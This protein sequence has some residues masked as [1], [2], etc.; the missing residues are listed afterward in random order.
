MVTNMKRD[1]EYGSKRNKDVHCLYPL[2]LFPFLRKP[3][4][5]IVDSDN[6]HVFQH[7][8]RHFGQPFLVLMSPEEVPPPLHEEQDKGSLFTLFLH[9]P[10]TAICLISTIIEIPYTLWEEAQSYIDRFYI[11]AG[12]QLVRSKNVDPVYLQFY[13][14]DFLRLLVLRFIFCSCITK[15]HRRFRVSSNI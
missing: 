3:F 2:D 6:S 15:M 9:S 7:I 5:L 10:L 12:K 14:D 11:E 4:F 1:Q 13:G 8:P